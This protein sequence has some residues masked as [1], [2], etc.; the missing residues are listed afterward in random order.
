[1]QVTPQTKAQGILGKPCH[2]TREEGYKPPN[3]SKNTSTEMSFY[4]SIYNGQQL[5]DSNVRM[6]VYLVKITWG[7][8]TFIS[9]SLSRFIWV[10]EISAAQYMDSS[11]SKKEHII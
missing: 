1:M 8:N 9:Q 2:R 10:T 7:A 3:T 5:P 11:C 6:F 4:G